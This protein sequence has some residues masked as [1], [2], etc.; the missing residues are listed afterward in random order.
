MLLMPVFELRADRNSEIS[1]HN[2]LLLSRLERIHKKLP[3]RFDV[4]HHSEELLSAPRPSNLPSWQREQDRI[5]VENR[6][7]KRRLNQTKAS[8]DTKQ[9]RVDADRH[10]YFADQISKA[11]RRMQVKQQC[12]QLE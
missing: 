4:S 3:K 7:M 11:E 1:L 2:S 12:M 9:L 5:A 6:K 8:F 10:R